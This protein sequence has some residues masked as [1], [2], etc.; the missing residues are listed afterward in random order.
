MRIRLQA[1]RPELTAKS[2]S[3]A[4]S[5]AQPIAAPSPRLALEKAGSPPAPSAL[6]SAASSQLTPV[7]HPGTT[8]EKP[9]LPDHLRAG[10]ESIS[11]LTLDDV[12]VHYNSPEPSR[13]QALAY[14]KGRDIHLGPG[15]E[16]HLPHEAWHAVYRRSHF[17]RPRQPHEKEE[18]G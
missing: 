4:L 18:A 13:H 7:H 9:G 15:Q 2:A 3:E 17:R 12:R 5:R 16:K 11:R 6:A 14:T 8:P 1:P 10:V